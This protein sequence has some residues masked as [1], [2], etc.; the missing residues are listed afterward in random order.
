[1]NTNL[2]RRKILKLSNACLATMA[3]FVLLTQPAAAE[4]QVVSSHVPAVLAHL[5]P[6]DRL[7]RS[8]QLD[9]S[10]GLPLRNREELNELLRQLSD[11]ASP[12]YHHYLSPEEFAQRFGPTEADCQAGVAFAKSNG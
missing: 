6:L 8:R 10:I 11:P 5:R 3:S 7:D 9:L 12:Q 4:R 2:I 1:M